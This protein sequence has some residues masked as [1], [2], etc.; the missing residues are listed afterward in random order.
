MIWSWLRRRVTTAPPPARIAQPKSTPAIGRVHV[1]APT[2]QLTPQRKLW[3]HRTREEKLATAPYSL[4]WEDGYNAAYRAF[5]KH[6][7]VPDVL[8]EERRRR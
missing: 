5:E 8:G 3:H 6:G 7:A 4:G 1:T 2:P